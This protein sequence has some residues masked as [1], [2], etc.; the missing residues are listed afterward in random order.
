M[1]GGLELYANTGNSNI[2]VPTSENYDILGESIFWG[3]R[4]LF[5]DDKD[6]KNGKNWIKIY[7]VLAAGMTVQIY[8]QKVQGDDFIANLGLSYFDFTTK[9]APKTYYLQLAQETDNIKGKTISLGFV[10]LCWCTLYKGGF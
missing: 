5:F 3:G 6:F 8:W 7:M 9:D 4:G 2:V 10:R 1:S